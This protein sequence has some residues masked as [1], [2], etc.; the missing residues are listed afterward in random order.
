M[1]AGCLEGTQSEHSGPNTPSSPQKLYIIHTNHQPNPSP[2]TQNPKLSPTLILRGPTKPPGPERTQDFGWGQRDRIGSYPV[3]K[4]S[5]WDRTGFILSVRNRNRTERD[6]SET[7]RD[8][9]GQ[10]RIDPEQLFRVTH[11]PIRNLER[12]T[13][14]SPPVSPLVV[15]LS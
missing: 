2:R 7:V 1:Y 11:N 9:T 12:K 10:D 5:E 4:I 6:V 14:R 15:V 8:R 13:S 3:P